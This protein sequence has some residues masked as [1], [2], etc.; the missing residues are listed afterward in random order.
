MVDTISATTLEE[1]D[2]L[3][4]SRYQL[5]ISIASNSLFLCVALCPFVLPSAEILFGLSLGRPFA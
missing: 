4:P 5:Q 1:I 2:F 3:F